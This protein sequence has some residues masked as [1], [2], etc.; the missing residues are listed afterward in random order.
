M[1][2][3]MFQGPFESE[4]VRANLA[5]LEGA[6]REAAGF[7]AGLLICPE[8]FLS[9]YAIGPD[10][11]RAAAEPVDGPSA[12]RTAAIARDAGI[13][14]LYGYPELGEDGLVYNAAL[15]LDRHGRR[16]ANHRKTHLF[17]DLDRS[18]FAPG[19]GPPTLA[20]IDGMRVGGAP[21]WRTVLDVSLPTTLDGPQA[22][23]ATVGCPFALG[24]QHVTYAALQLRT[25]LSPMAFQ[26]TDTIAG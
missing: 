20:E 6:A 18:A 13:A 4:G 11:V 17:S 25:R 15:L 8:M 3:A 22:L 7:G 10:R 9:G 12:A 21:A 26:P 16:L 1:R 14:L 24:P 19:H 2:I 23:C 5:R